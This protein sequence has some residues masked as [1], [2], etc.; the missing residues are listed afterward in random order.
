MCSISCPSWFSTW[1]KWSIIYLQLYE[2]TMKVRVTQQLTFAQLLNLTIFL[3]IINGQ[4]LCQAVLLPQLRFCILWLI[5]FLCVLTK[6]DWIITSPR[7]LIYAINK[8]DFQL[9][10]NCSCQLLYKNI[11]FSNNI[12]KVWIHD[13]QSN[14]VNIAYALQTNYFLK[15]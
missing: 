15:Y 6:D 1:S 7:L 13:M 10:Q 3:A 12:K 8:Q 4:Y 9:L 14:S 11:H 5:H 2:V